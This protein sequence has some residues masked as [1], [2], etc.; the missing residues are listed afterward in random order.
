V[1]PVAGL[2]E[3][4]VQGR[5]PLL[6]GLVAEKDVRTVEDHPWRQ[7]LGPFRS[8]VTAVTKPGELILD[9]CA[10]QGTTGVAAVIEGRRFLGVDTDAGVLALTRER[11]TDLHDG[12]GA[13]DTTPVR[14]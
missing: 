5:A 11:L 10:G 3:R 2:L 7:T 8:I 13:D 14:G 1:A 9:P 4:A 12:T 6:D